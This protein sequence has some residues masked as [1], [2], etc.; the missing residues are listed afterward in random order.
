MNPK[1]F[2]TSTGQLDSWVSLLQE[3]AQ[4]DADVE[5]RENVVKQELELPDLTRQEAVL[6]GTCIPFHEDILMLAGAY[7]TRESCLRPA[8]QESVICVD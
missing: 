7:L 3:P 2:T 4:V 1:L 6:R 8:H 5:G